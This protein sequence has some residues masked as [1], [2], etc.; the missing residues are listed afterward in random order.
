[1][2][3]IFLILIIFILTNCSKHK[4]VLICGDHACVNKTEAEQ[5][6]EEN[7][8]IEVRII[9]KKIERNIDLVELNLNKNDDGKKKISVSSK[10]ATKKKLKTLS[11]KE[12]I[13]IK[14][15]IKNKKKSKK[16]VK[17]VDT[18]LQKEK[19]EIKNENTT[20]GQII[21]QKGNIF[22][23]NNVNKK[24]NDVIDICTLLEKCS[25]DEISKYLIDRG[26]KK[27]F[28]DITIRQ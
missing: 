8:T 10:K 19:K 27:N 18:E 17:K 11:E 1:M 16:I 4:T 26:K 3:F 24:R 5:Y 13:D 15:K 7:L 21:K 2:K 14:A 9:D 22:I 6:F 12:V 25:I 23:Q 20:K 28:P